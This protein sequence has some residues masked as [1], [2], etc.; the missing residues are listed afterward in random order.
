MS[1]KTTDVL[2][3]ACGDRTEKLLT[4]DV[5]IQHKTCLRVGESNKIMPHKDEKPSAEESQEPPDETSEGQSFSSNRDTCE[6]QLEQGL[7]AKAVLN[8]KDVAEEETIE[9]EVCFLKE[10]RLEVQGCKEGEDIHEE[11]SSFKKEHSMT[12]E[13]LIDMQVEYVASYNKEAEHDCGVDSDETDSDVDPIEYLECGRCKWRFHYEVIGFDPL[14][15]TALRQCTSTGFM[16]FCEVCRHAVAY[17]LEKPI[18]E[19]VAVMQEKVESFKWLAYQK[20]QGERE[21]EG[22]DLKCY[23]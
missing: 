5:D 1:D 7:E 15:L 21:E 20:F 8:N 14:F 13:E 11:S 6:K 23:R 16:W 19:R 3:Q 17:E 22:K 2:K 4:K 18:E 9:T 10:E 12:E